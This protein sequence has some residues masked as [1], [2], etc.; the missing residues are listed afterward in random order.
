MIATQNRADAV[1]S[2][3]DDYFFQ[4]DGHLIPNEL[5]PVKFA[6]IAPH[7]PVQLLNY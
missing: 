3:V 7:I 5:H 2:L 4:L 1:K 6:K